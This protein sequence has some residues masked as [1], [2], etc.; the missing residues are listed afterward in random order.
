[1]SD[2][3]FDR[4]QQAHT[5]CDAESASQPGQ[6]DRVTQ[7]RSGSVGF[8]IADALGCYASAV[9]SVNNQLG[10]DGGIGHGIAVGP[11]AVINR[12]GAYHAMNMIA[13]GQ[14]PVQ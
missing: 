7:G 13:I 5:R 9:Q 3:G 14:C 12:S 1:M 6:L 4:A 2:V 10:L 8:D 11:T